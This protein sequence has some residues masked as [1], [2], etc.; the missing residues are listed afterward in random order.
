[1]ENLRNEQFLSCKLHTVL[2]SVMKS[3]A[4]LPYPSSPLSHVCAVYAAWYIASAQQMFVERRMR[5]RIERR[6]EGREGGRKNGR[7]EE[8]IKVKEK[9]KKGSKE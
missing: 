3:R 8:R 6:E 1:M 7:K 5:G 9:E 4:V 2:G